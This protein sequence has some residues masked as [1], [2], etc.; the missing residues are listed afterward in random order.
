MKP[1]RTPS[2]DR[3]AQGEGEGGGGSELRLAASTDRRY[4]IS[5]R[6]QFSIDC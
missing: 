3:G 1:E 2:R 6:M 4:L 5:V